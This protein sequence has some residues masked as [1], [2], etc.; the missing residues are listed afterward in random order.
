[1]NKKDFNLPVKDIDLDDGLNVS[2]IIQQ[3]SSSGGFVAPNVS[4]GVNIIDTMIQDD[5]CSCFLSFPASIVATGLRGVLVEMIKRGW[6]KV[7]VTTCGTLD[8]DIARTISNYYQGDFRLDDSMLLKKRLHRLGNVIVPFDSYGSLIEKQLLPILNE[9]TSEKG[10][11]I[12]ISSLSW[13]IGELLNDDSSLLFWC[14]KMKVPIII[15]APLDGAVGNQ[16]WLFSQNNRDLSIDLMDDQEKLSEIIYTSKKTGA[17]IIG[18]GVSK[19]HTLWWNQFKGGLDYA[20]SLTTAHEYDGS[21]SGAEIREAI[22]WS[23]VKSE[24]KQVTINGEASSLLPFM[25]AAVIE[26]ISK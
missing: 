25:I 4:H 12:S 14:W 8:H 20:V 23:K 26:R 15:P 17:L 18:G 19:H 3:M 11:D 22:S 24:A 6:F 7:L 2:D 5:D 10:N 1:M 9:I 13:K 21:L 16:L